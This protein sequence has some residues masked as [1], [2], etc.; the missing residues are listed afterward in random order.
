[1]QKQRYHNYGF[2]EF[3]PPKD[4]EVSEHHY[5]EFFRTM[6][7]RQEV[8][9]KRFLLNQSAPWT[10]DEI[11]KDYKFTNVYRELDKHSQYLIKE[12]MI[13]ENT[14]SLNLVWKM[15]LFRIFNQPATFNFIKQ[16]YET[17]AWASGFCNWNDYKPNELSGYID[18][19]RKCNQNPFTEAYLINSQACPG[20]KRDF[21]Y[22]Q[23]ILPAIHKSIPKIIKLMKTAKTGKEFVKFLETLPGVGSFIAHEFYQDFTYIDR[24]CEDKFN[25]L[26]PFNQDDF[27][28]VG[29]GAEVGIRLILP[30]RSTPQEKLQGIYDLRDLAKDTLATIGNFKYLTWDRDTKTYGVSEDNEKFDITLHQIEMWLCEYQKY[31]KMTIGVGKQRSKFKP[32]TK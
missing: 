19:V 9:N 20:C 8:W 4:E 2:F 16:N 29:P 21:C 3:L 14:N 6:F 25:G 23:V 28:N 27:T 13:P 26:F 17:P 1:M 11:L 30:S 10:E 15:M 22:T 32:R 7:E 24:Y 18:E 31:W 5:N 12:V